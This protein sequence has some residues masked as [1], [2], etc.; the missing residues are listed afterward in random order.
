MPILP[1]LADLPFA[2]HLVEHEGA[3]G[4]GESYDTVLFDG[5]ERAER[6]VS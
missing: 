2:A 5:A 1:E 3:L 6:A 4:S